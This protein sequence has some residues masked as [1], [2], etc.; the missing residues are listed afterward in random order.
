MDSR[1]CRR[2]GR[3]PALVGDTL[4]LALRL[5]H[6]WAVGEL[7]FWMWRAGALDAPPEGAAEPYAH[8]IAGDRV[9]VE[10][11]PYDLTKGRLTFRYKQALHDTG[12]SHGDGPSPASR[13]RV[14][15]AAAPRP[16]RAATGRRVLPGRHRRGG[17]EGKGGPRGVG[18]A[19]AAAPCR[20]FAAASTRP[21]RCCC[22]CFACCRVW[23]WAVSTAA[24]C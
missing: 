10:M 7:A 13:P 20:A 22:W 18:P 6:R 16:P 9:H 21:A 12:R 2:A 15:R 3:I 1:W 17:A 8:Q 24:R 11:T 23:P 14:G 4:D 5:H 19:S